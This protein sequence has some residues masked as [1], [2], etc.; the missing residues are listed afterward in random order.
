MLKLF[1]HKHKSNPNFWKRIVIGIIGIAYFYFFSH[2]MAISHVY[3]SP[4][5][6]KG[7]DITYWLVSFTQLLRIIV[8]N[9]YSAF[10]FDLII[11]LTLISSFIFTKK[12]WLTGLLGLLMLIYHILFNYKIGYHAHYLFGFH[13]ALFPF[14]FHQ[15]LFN[16]AVGFARIIVCLNYASSGFFKI[17]HKAWAFPDN[18]SNLLQGQHAG[19]MYFNPNSLQTKIYA[20]L[21][22]NPL[23][24]YGILL[25][26]IAL[27]LSFL[28]VILINKYN[29][30]I[31]I[32][33]I[34]F[35]VSDWFL[36]N[37]GIFMCFLPMAW[38]FVYDNKFEINF[39][40]FK[41]KS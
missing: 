30:I 33:L 29:K 10:Y 36:M 9:Y 41:L 3:D 2:G 27:Q 23:I 1:Y 5:Q 26:A 6:F 24:G 32:F 39:H 20:W 21:I 16:W 18:F 34:L 22:D 31:F 13:V 28:A 14:Y 12:R 7:G 37:L 8:Y 15:N 40:N 35:H 19:F 4:F 17:L 11:F 38:V 25:S